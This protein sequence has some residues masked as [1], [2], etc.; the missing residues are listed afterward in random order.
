IALNGGNS[1]F[2]YSLEGYRNEVNK[3]V[4]RSTL[5]QI[6]NKELAFQNMY[7]LLRPGGH[8]GIMFSIVNPLDACWL[9]ISAS[10]YW[11]S[12]SRRRLLQKCI[13]KYWFS[14]RSMCERSDMQYQFLNDQSFIR[15]WLEYTTVLLR[16]PA[17]T[18]PQ[19]NEESISLF[20]ELIGYGGSGPLTY[21]HSELLL[22]AIKPEDGR[23]S[24]K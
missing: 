11:P 12:K 16:I 3:I 9:R 2:R 22:L 20:K 4:C 14:G 13:G 6:A 5:Q 10:P 24:E 1:F 17:D 7:N 8:A 21:E 19:F 15:E 23:N 18:I